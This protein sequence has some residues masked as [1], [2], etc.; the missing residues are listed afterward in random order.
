MGGRYGEG[1]LRAEL[2][3]AFALNQLGVPQSDDVSNCKSYLASWLAAL[4]QD[5]RFIFNV[6]SDASRAR[7]FLLSFSREQVEEAEPA[8][9]I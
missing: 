7:D 4:H 8:I 1:E 2:T 3:W 9:V 5:P 6:S